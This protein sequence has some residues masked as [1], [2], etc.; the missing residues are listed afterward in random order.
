MV[1]VRTF[2]GVFENIRGHNCAIKATFTVAENEQ[3][4]GQIGRTDMNKYDIAIIGAGPGGYSAALFA[5][6]K[7]KKVALFEERAIGGVCLNEGCIPTK[8]LLHSAHLL[9]DIRESAKCGIK[10]EGDLTIDFKRIAARKTKIVRK[11][12]AGVSMRLKEAGVEVIATR[13]QLNGEADGAIRIVADGKEYLAT[14]VILAA[15]SETVIPPIPGVETSGYITSREALDAKELPQSI[16]I[17]GGGVIGIEFADFYQSMGVK[18][19][20]IEMMPEILGNMD[21]ETSAMLRES[22]TKRG[23]EILLQTKVTALAP[24]EVT[25]EKQDGTSETLQAE[26]TLL[27]V[28][29]RPQ[30]KG[31]GLESLSIEMNRAAVKTNEYLQTSHPH[32][33]AIGDLNGVSL[34]AHTAVREGE[35]AVE[36]IL[37]APNAPKMCYRAIPGIVYTHPEIAGVGATEEALQASGEPYQVKKLPMSYAGRF[38]VESEGVNGLCKIIT[39]KEDRII[40]CHLLGNPAS[41]IILIA[42]IAVAEGMKAE[43]FRRNCFPHPTVGEILHETLLEG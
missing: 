35:V 11:L 26:K 14:D 24:G 1:G 25:I 31:L 39:D 22:L 9:E 27:C 7:G 32:V 15:G 33:Y 34:L 37:N 13:A 21:K 10:Y 16:A 3:T 18:V 29:R 36:H 28:G 12:T 8:T 23:I 41:E 2:K 40:G 20:V 4:N 6:S 38:I 42:A 5:A 17:I 43:D 19:T 30:S